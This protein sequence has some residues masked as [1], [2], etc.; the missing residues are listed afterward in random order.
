[1]LFG[2]GASSSGR[3]SKGPSS[4]RLIDEGLKINR[5]HASSAGG[6]REPC[7]LPFD[8]GPAIDLAGGEMFQSGPI[9]CKGSRG[10]PAIDS[11]LALGIPILAGRC[12]SLCR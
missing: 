1:M 9:V 4:D 3:G 5:Q 10:R 12:S 2:G 8:L 7:G 11:W 6:I